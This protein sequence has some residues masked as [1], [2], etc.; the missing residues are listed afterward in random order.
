MLEPGCLRA[1]PL[2]GPER[3]GYEA[4]A[5]GGDCVGGCNSKKG[6]TIVYPSPNSSTPTAFVFLTG[7]S[8][9]FTGLS[10]FS[11]AAYRLTLN[12]PSSAPRWR[13][14]HCKAASGDPQAM[15]IENG[16]ADRRLQRRS[17]SGISRAMSSR[18]TGPAP[19][20]QCA[21]IPAR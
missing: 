17:R 1:D 8:N 2:R 5:Q 4:P 21:A 16:Q 12:A 7:S 19:A 11:I 20:T 6:P 9:Q 15:E 10:S 13:W 14:S 3:R 18:Q